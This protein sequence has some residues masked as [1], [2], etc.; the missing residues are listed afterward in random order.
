M[1]FNKGSFSNSTI[2]D[3]DQLKF[4]NILCSLKR[5]KFKNLNLG[6][7][8]FRR[9]LDKNKKNK[10]NNKDKREKNRDVPFSNK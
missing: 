5:M 8:V 6:K 9:R 7:V 4:W 10:H 3:K 1:S 2:S